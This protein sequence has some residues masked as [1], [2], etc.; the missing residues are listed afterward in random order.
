MRQSD[1]ERTLRAAGRWPASHMDEALMH[2]AC[3]LTGE[4]AQ[5]VLHVPPVLRRRNGGVSS[6]S[7]GD[8]SQKLSQNLGRRGGRRCS[9]RHGDDERACGRRIRRWRARGAR[10]R[11]RVRLQL[12]GDVLACRDRPRGQDGQHTLEREHTVSGL[13]ANLQPRFQPCEPTVRFQSREVSA[14][15]RDVEHRRAPRRKPRQRRMG[16]SVVGR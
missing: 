15:A 3:V 16:T 2:G 9:K 13:R 8:L 10:C 14:E 4:N 12:P 7:K 5:G 6:S 1:N 11:V